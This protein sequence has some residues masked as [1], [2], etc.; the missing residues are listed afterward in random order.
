MLGQSNALKELVIDSFCLKTIVGVILDTLPIF[1]RM[2]H[3][4]FRAHI[5][6]TIPQLALFTR[7][8]AWDSNAC[9]QFL[10]NAESDFP[11]SCLGGVPET[12]LQHV[13]IEGL[14]CDSSFGGVSKCH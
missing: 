4:K 7:P 2:S 14:P 3:A 5:R 6:N 9:C 8:H 13:E 10:A 11:I 12:G 1:K